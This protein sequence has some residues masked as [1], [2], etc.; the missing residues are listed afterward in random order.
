MCR[1]NTGDMNNPSSHELDIFRLHSCRRL[2]VVE[3][4]AH[5]GDEESGPMMGALISD[6][7][8]TASK[9]KFGSCA[10]STERAGH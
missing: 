2:L 8:D 7:A 9:N 5:L 1:F 6:S 10:T 3:G 4:H